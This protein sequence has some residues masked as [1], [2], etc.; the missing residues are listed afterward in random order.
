MT[1]KQPV[2]ARFQNRDHVELSE[3]AEASRFSERCGDARLGRRLAL[4]VAVKAQAGRKMRVLVVV[5]VYGHRKVEWSGCILSVREENSGRRPVAFAFLHPHG[6]AVLQGLPFGT[7]RL[8]LQPYGPAIWTETLN[9][10]TPEQIEQQGWLEPRLV[11]GALA[12]RAAKGSDPA[13]EGAEAV[14]VLGALARRSEALAGPALGACLR[15]LCNSA[16]PPELR[17]SASKSIT[18][19]NNAF[20]SSIDL[21]R[22]F[23]SL[24]RPPETFQEAEES[25]AIERK[26]YKAFGV[27]LASRPMIGA[28]EKKLLEVLVARSQMEAA[29]PRALA[30]HT[31]SGVRTRGAVG[32]PINKKLLLT[33]ARNGGSSV[34]DALT[35]I[36]KALP[37]SGSVLASLRKRTL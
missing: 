17:S 32:P 6:V 15:L 18:K 25:E 29:P 4:R 33:L 2:A 24:S 3:L 35:D 13:T 11:C 27:V 7:Y 12:G 26:I 19:K 20:L 23:P 9:L 1:L 8:S 21:S 16:L 14:A 30:R 36:L 31:S 10:P 22:F 34:C 37:G 5:H 28:E